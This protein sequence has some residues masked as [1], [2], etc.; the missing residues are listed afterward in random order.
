MRGRK[1]KK[2]E[3]VWKETVTTIRLSLGHDVQNQEQTQEDECELNW[4]GWTEKRQDWCWESKDEDSERMKIR[5]DD[6]DKKSRRREDDG[7]RK[8]VE[9]C[10]QKIGRKSWKTNSTHFIWI[11]RLETITF[12]LPR[13]LASKNF[14]LTT[15]HL[16]WWMVEYSTSLFSTSS[17]PCTSFQALNM[18]EYS[19]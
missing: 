19:L 16:K 6:E 1:V 7:W 14:F 8:R 4:E 13:F 12:F 3:T 18:T 5:N 2:K 17:F 10:R 9:K 11:V 15:F